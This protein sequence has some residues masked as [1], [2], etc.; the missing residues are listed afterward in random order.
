MRSD[1][2]RRCSSAVAYFG[3]GGLRERDLRRCEPK[4]DRRRERDAY[5]E[6]DR[7]RE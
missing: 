3:R 4:G 7:E 1:S 2:A 6:R 5:G